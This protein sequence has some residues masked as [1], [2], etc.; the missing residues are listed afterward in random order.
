MLFVCQSRE[1]KKAY[2]NSA[3]KVRF[4][5]KKM[6]RNTFTVSSSC[7]VRNFGPNSIKHLVILI[8]RGRITLK[9]ILSVQNLSVLQ[10]RPL[11]REI[12]LIDFTLAYTNIFQG[13]MSVRLNKELSAL[14]HVRFTETPLYF[15]IYTCYHVSKLS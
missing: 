5:H 14:Y 15:M 6:L 11:Y 8:Y 10:R 4:Q 3:K 13:Q 2:I 9:L 7:R 1:K 12:L